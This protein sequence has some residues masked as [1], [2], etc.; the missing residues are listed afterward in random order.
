ML[1]SAPSQLG[2]LFLMLLVTCWPAA[3]ATRHAPTL[4]TAPTVIDGPSPN[5]LGLSGLAIARDGTGTVVYLKTVSGV[6][7][8]FASSLLNGRFG[9]PVQV[10]T[11]LAGPSSQPV[12]AATNQGFTLV[13]FI[14]G[15]ELYTIERPSALAAWGPPM[16]L[17]NGASDPSLS[18]STFG[19]AYLAFTGAGAGGH[20]VRVAYFNL[21]QWALAP[22]PLDANP[23]DDAG[24]GTG[25]P[26]VATAGDGTGIVA[27]GEDGHIYTRQV[28]GSSPSPVFALVDPPSVSGW[29]EV[30]ADEPVIGTGGDSAYASLA[31]R[32]VVTDG[33]TQQSRV[34]DN[35]WH[36]AFYDGAKPADGLSTPGPE[37]AQAPG[38]AVA[39]Y[40]T[41]LVTAQREQSNNLFVSTLGEN[42]SLGPAAQLNTMFQQS[43]ADAV[44]ATAGTASLFV[45]WQQDPG[46]AGTP[47]IRVRYA[48]DG[49][50]LGSEVV[51]STPGLGPANAALGLAA[52]GDVAG[53]AAVA[54]VQGSGAQTQIVAN[55]L[56]QPPGV[57]NPSVVFRYATSVNPVLTWSAAS[58]LWGPVQYIVKLDGVQIADTTATRIRAPAPVAQG[59]HSWQVTAVNLGGVATAGRASTVFVDSV[60]PKVSVRIT[61]ARHV[62]SE[63]HLTVSYTDAPRGVRRSAGSGVRSVQVKWGDG[64]RYSIR[65]G[66]Y[67]AY[68][69]RGTYT[70]TVTVSDRAGNKTI[71]IRKL[72]ITPPPKPKRGRR[73]HRR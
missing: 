4:A 33:V 36:A 66:K 31:F 52:G 54:W 24:T 41:G 11:G 51:V 39:E 68:S 2:A 18:M 28:L 56:F 63:L 71:V 6:A 55:Q 42:E 48:P 19:K 22:T 47:D 17:F 25:R 65:H 69:R 60:P 38:V 46:S 37:G 62:H 1:R 8:V 15:G 58:E 10:D 32:E 73:A 12:V 7:H 29:S 44:P 59:R 23:S 13:A 49:T 3:A 57:F 70:V 35:R 27:W 9:A 45:A 5:I 16:P 30:S 64:S 61:G 67:H 53:D 34:L 14:N 20:D 50:D 40:G 72:K 43:P 21:G 26:Q